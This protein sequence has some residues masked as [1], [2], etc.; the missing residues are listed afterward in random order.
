MVTFNVT[1][2]LEL[3]LGVWLDVTRLPGD[4][5]DSR[6]LSYEI[7][8]GGGD[9]SPT[10]TPTQ[11]TV[12]YFDPDCLLDGE[13]PH[14]PYYG[15][16]VTG[17]PMR[18]T[19]DGD[20]RAVVELSTYQTEWDSGH[21]YVHAEMIGM[22]VLHRMGGS[23]LRPLA[24]PA[25]RS[26]AS[27]D[28]DDYRIV[29]VPFEEESEATRIGV[30]QN[31]T[32]ALF[33]GE[34]TLGGDGNS[35]GAARLVTLGDLGKLFVRV[36]DYTSTEHKVLG[37]WRFPT[38][39]GGS[40]IPDNSVI[41]EF[42]TQ[43]NVDRVWLVYLTGGG[44]RLQAYLG[45]VLVDQTGIIGFGTEYLGD[46]QEVLISLEF[47]QSGANMDTRMFVIGSIGGQT[48]WD[49]TFTSVTITRFTSVRVGHTDISGVSF[50]QLVVGN[51]TTAFAN[52]MSII[53]GTSGLKGYAGEPAGT[54]IQ[55][56]AGEEFI[57]FDFTGV[58]SDTEPVGVQG[59]ESIGTLW[60]QAAAVDM[61]I[62]HSSR[63]DNAGA[64]RTRVSLYNQVP[65]ATLSYAHVSPPFVPVADDN[66]LR[67][68]VE[69]S[70]SG[71]SSAT[72]TIP[73]GDFWHRT[74]ED[75]P[76]GVG[77]RPASI[78]PHAD[79]DDQLNELAAWDAHL[80][81]WKA[82]RITAVTFELARSV[83][84]ADDRTAVRSIN[85]GDV[86]A[87]ETVAAPNVLP[88]NEY[89]L[90]ARGYR[91]QGSK[92]LHTI[93]FNTL[94]AD[95]YE[96]EVVDPGGSE[97]AV[98]I[99]ADDTSLILATTAGLEWSVTDPPYHIQVG[100]EAM[101]VTA[102]STETPAFIAAGAAANANN[103][104]VTPGLPAGMT[105]NTGQLMLLFAA[106][107]NSGTGTVN[108]PTGWT[109]LQAFG[110]MA[111]FG[112]YYRTGD[113]APTVSFTGGVAGA[114]TSAVIVA[115][116]GL[117]MG[118]ASGKLETPAFVTQLNA[119]AQ[120]IVYPL[121]RIPGDRSGV[122]FIFAWKQDDNSAATTPSGFTAMFNQAPTTGDDHSM[123]GRYDLTAANVSAG[124][125]T[126]TGGAAA[127]SRV[128]LFALRPLQTA[129][130]TRA[131]NG[132]STSH[133]VGGAVRSWR[134]GIGAL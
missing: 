126:M 95:A 4:A 122:G 28:N 130:V 14:S 63:D 31:V 5:E 134:P 133:S 25:Y 104:S 44:L 111:V 86:M 91:E 77:R 57:I 70:R 11:L 60:E 64:Y 76:D 90:M 96:V 99:D 43:G 23:N 87:I 19:V 114:D 49:E 33:S 54:R 12:R 41:Y 73:D 34:L 21:N 59:L 22:D 30:Y 75:P 101:T 78:S 94:P 119:S 124:T 9:E 56:L 132:V 118:V 48:Q 74:T 29:Y 117:S 17:T 85:L 61:G 100:G 108:T 7:V 27:P 107:R 105:V 46:A 112:R 113:A 82:K 6:V 20:V 58:K 67:N 79:T 83:F 110:N 62:L 26:I 89:R 47:T 121:M 16:I 35:A 52:Y 1:L 125:V 65:K 15:L 39:G 45:A 103:A 13:N 81:S 37:T 40:E 127:I 102:M 36:P 38:I 68:E 3:S 84:T 71:G 109:S 106:I 92:F 131:V 50:G 42:R 69:A 97:L 2:E 18:I 116:S 32:Y 53:N 80:G 115:F 129:T 128:M 55:R 24:S 123:V 8:R 98:A 66:R 51:E 93:T 72:Y 120:N 88:D 10:V